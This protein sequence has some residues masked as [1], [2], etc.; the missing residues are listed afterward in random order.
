MVGAGEFT[1]REAI[2]VAKNVGGLAVARGGGLA[3]VDSVSE[4]LREETIEVAVDI[5]LQSEHVG[6]RKFF[7]ALKITIDALGTN[8]GIPFETDDVRVYIGR[9]AAIGGCEYP[10]GRI[11]STR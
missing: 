1:L 7:V 8:G 2:P 5:S 11:V 10:R 3:V 4:A 6:R 9:D